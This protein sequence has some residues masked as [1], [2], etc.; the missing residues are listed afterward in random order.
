MDWEDIGEIGISEREKE[1]IN[2]LLKLSENTEA[3]M[4]ETFPY[5][6]KA[7]KK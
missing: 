4:Y 6:V 5:T 1:I 3:W 2:I 7:Q